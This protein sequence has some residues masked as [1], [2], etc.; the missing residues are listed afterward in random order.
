[1]TGTAFSASLS[2]LNALDCATVT[3]TVPDARPSINSSL[4]STLPRFLDGLLHGTRLGFHG[5]LDGA[6]EACF[7]GTEAPTFPVIPGGD[8]LI[9]LPII[10]IPTTIHVCSSD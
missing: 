7:D 8:A 9:Y 4:S 5:L 10:E 6:A 1:M 3:E 2:H